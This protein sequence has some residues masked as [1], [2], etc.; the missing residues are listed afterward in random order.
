MA[1]N[2]PATPA[3]KPELTFEKLAEARAL[4]APP[5]GKQP[6]EYAHADSPHIKLR[7]HPPTLEG[8]IRRQ[9]V[10]RARY[11]L[12]GETKEERNAYLELDDLQELP[13]KEALAR[14]QGGINSILQR[15][16]EIEKLRK[17]T[18]EQAAEAAKANQRMT[19]AD[20]WRRWP[21][22]TRL[23][24]A[25]TAL[26]EQGVY[27]RYFAH[28]ADRYLDELSYTN[29]WSHFVGGIA[30]GKLLNADGLTYSKLPREQ[31]SEATLA[32]V[33]NLGAKLYKLAGEEGLPG[34][35][36][37]WNPAR[38]ALRQLVGT[39][40][41]RNSSIPLTKLVALWRASDVMCASWA[42]DHLRFYLLTG[43]RHSLLSALT[44]AEVDSA[45]RVLRISPHK[46]GTKRR[47]A[48]TPANA[49]DIVIPISQSAVRIIDARRAWAPDPE[50][51]VWY[52]LSQH[53]GKARKSGVPVHSDP[54]SNWAHLST[55]VLDGMHFMRHDLRRTFARIAVRAG[56]DVM[57]TSL[58]MLHS[59]RTVARLMNI[60]DIT[61]QYMNFP[62]AQAQMRSAARSIE[63]FLGG[64]LDG[65][66][67]LDA[68]AE[69]EPELPSILEEAVGGPDS[70][71]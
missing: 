6:W 40:N 49:P 47:G 32:G 51:P 57:G 20:A 7:V 9:L 64:L 29:F 71:D 65:S 61:A 39:P 44:F 46:Q 68:L 35:P 25:Q 53:G 1:A 34:K 52:M 42:R 43:L 41:V 10:I 70:D 11:T 5:R 18:P 21:V 16:D 24:R 36:K 19:V 63:K 12:Q 56:A 45:A 3:K 14:W 55:H 4:K 50:G 33:M 27:R 69:D 54:R 37:D 48:D 28:L 67:N 23:D 8:H 62:E 2:H 30:K 38:D 31:Y 58:L 13:G 26:K 15:V 22:E 59:P 17:A 60:A 66:I